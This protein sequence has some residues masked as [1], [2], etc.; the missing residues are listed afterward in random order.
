[1]GPIL[2]KCFSFKCKLL[3]YYFSISCSR[4]TK[5]KYFLNIHSNWLSDPAQIDIRTTALTA[6]HS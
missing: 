4:P 6:M 5:S 3:W 2:V 1:M